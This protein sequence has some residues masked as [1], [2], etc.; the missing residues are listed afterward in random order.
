MEMRF[1]QEVPDLFRILIH[2]EPQTDN[3]R[4]FDISDRPDERKPAP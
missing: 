4:G 2:T 1:K 3:A